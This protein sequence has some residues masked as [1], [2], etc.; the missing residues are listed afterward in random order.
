MCI[1]CVLND[2]RKALEESKQETDIVYGSMLEPT[3]VTAEE[4]Q[5]LD[6][7]KPSKPNQL[8]N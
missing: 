3:E 1:V 6:I 7:V 5:N 8:L 2:F 4:I